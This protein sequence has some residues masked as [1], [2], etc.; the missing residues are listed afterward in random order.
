LVAFCPLSQVE[1]VRNALFDAGAGHTGNY[2]QCSFNIEGTGTFRAYGKA[3][4]F[5]GE[6]NKLHH[7][8]EVRIEVIFQNHLR[9]KV[10]TALIA[11]HP[12]EEVAYDLYPLSNTYTKAGAGLVGS[13]S[14]SMP[15]KEFLEQVK[16]A[17]QCSCIRHTR[18]RNIPIRKVALCTGAG[19]FLIPDAIRAGADV[20]LTADLK[21][22]DFFLSGDQM[23]LADIGHYESEKGVKEWLYA[24]LIEKFSTFAVLISEINTNPVNYF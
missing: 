15:E 20:F 22:H 2:D 19:S 12:Y 24:K 16:S 11:H 7:E 14:R 18:L 5:V 10:I 8:S 4:P 9:D 3:N 13:L 17:L 6:M 21:Y 1:K 23:V